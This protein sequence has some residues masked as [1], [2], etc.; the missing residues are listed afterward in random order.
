MRNQRKRIQSSDWMRSAG[1]L[2]V[3]LT[4]IPILVGIHVGSYFNHESTGALVGAIAGLAL[5]V[6]LVI[7]PLWL[8]ADQK[9]SS[10]HSSDQ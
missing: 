3:A 4:V 6:W 9:Q 1:F 8:E 10:S 7:R 5:A 2:F